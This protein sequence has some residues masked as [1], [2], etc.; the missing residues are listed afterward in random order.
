MMTNHANAQA[1]CISPS[2][3]R[4]GEKVQT[5]QRC[6]QTHSDSGA[7]FLMLRVITSYAR[8]RNI[9]KLILLKDAKMRTKGKRRILKRY[10]FRQFASLLLNVVIL[11]HKKTKKGE[12]NQHD[13]VTGVIGTGLD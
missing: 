8:Q 11:Q 7:E 2:T 1:I 12:L 9:R 13:E 4:C 6:R 5:I 3:R 10:F